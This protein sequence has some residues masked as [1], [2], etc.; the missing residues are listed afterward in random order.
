MAPWSG[1]GRRGE[2][3]SGEAQE[4]AADGSGPNVLGRAAEAEGGFAGSR[5]GMPESLMSLSWQ[6]GADIQDSHNDVA[7]VQYSA[8]K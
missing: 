7:Q 2:P 1:E 4:G 6:P 8:G 3:S 5:I